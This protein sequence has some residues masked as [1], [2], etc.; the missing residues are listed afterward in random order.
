MQP[1]VSFFSTWLNKYYSAHWFLLLSKLNI[2]EI[3][4]KKFT[5]TI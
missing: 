3:K 2:K 5:S 4:S 1:I